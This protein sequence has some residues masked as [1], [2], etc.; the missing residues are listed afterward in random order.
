VEDRL[1]VLEV[2]R[3]GMRHCRKRMLGDDLVAVWEVM[4]IGLI[5]I[6]LLMISSTPDW[7][8]DVK[9]QISFT[10]RVRGLVPLRR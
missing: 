9:I 1:L 4:Q 6:G 8:V 3:S 10:W 2:R 7:L 5:L